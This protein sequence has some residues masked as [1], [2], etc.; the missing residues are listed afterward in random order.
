MQRVCLTKYIEND[1]SNSTSQKTKTKE[2]KQKHN[3]IIIISK[4]HKKFRKLP[5]F[6][7]HESLLLPLVVRQ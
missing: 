3:F 6:N 2:E 7:Y 4:T 5:L 1:I